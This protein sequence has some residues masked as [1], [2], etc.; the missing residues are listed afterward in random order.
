[1][2]N[3]A[4]HP[5]SYS[6]LCSFPPGEFEHLV[7]R[8]EGGLVIKK[9]A[10][11][12][13]MV[14][15][16]LHVTLVIATEEAW[17]VYD[18]SEYGISV[19]LPVQPKLVSSLSSDGN[20]RTTSYRALDEATVRQYT[21]FI[22]QP[23]QRGIFEPE[24]TDAFFDGHL[25][26]VVAHSA[27]GKILASKRVKFFGMPALEYSYKHRVDGIPFIAKGV[28]FIIDGGHVRLSMWYP[29]DDS[30][31]PA[32]YEK[33]LKSFKL[34]PIA[35]QPSSS[36][37]ND[38]R[39]IA[40]T[41]P[42]GWIK[43]KPRNAYEIARFSNLTR[44]ISLLAAGNRSY[45]CDAYKAELQRSGTVLEQSEVTLRGRKTQ[46][47]ITFEDVPKYNVRLTTAHYCLNSRIGAV[48][49]V[50]TE[51]Q[52]MYWRWASVIEGAAS[53]VNAPAP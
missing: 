37:I 10:L 11:L 16:F 29:L 13:G 34:L 52:P 20:G 6:E 17:P 27:S 50:G 26:S 51:E 47:I 19:A 8:E 7:P 39:E 42:L 32:L 24:S 25:K 3:L 30:E 53:T 15:I 31:G 44:S 4:F 48:V 45:N 21:I 5:T 36:P 41:P 46:K 2:P 18:L 9:F 43:G 22:G 33:F 14:I 12:C 49:L 28:T 40:F 1:M 35:Y 23:E 38:P